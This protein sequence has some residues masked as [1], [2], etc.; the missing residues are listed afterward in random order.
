L[1]DIGSFRQQ[2]KSNGKKV[3]FRYALFLNRIIVTNNAISRYIFGD[4][5]QRVSPI[6]PT[7]G[8]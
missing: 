6:E 4:T 3:P 2:V 7:K 1:N 5:K 8:G